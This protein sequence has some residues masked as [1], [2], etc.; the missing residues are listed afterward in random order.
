[1]IFLLSLC[2]LAVLII[3]S[4][5]IGMVLVILVGIVWIFVQGSKTGRGEVVGR[6]ERSIDS[7]HS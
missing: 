4:I 1:M 7:R 3:I 5:V 6:H 2:Q